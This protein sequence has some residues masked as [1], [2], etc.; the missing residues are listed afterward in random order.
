MVKG[1]HKHKPHWG[2]YSRWL[3]WEE[4]SWEDARIGR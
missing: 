3:V 1:I 2:K 4:L